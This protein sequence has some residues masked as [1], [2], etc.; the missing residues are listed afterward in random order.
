[1]HLADR[2]LCRGY[3][4]SVWDRNIPAN[5]IADDGSSMGAGSNLA[6]R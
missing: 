1:M 3:G 6:V 2:T 4:Y 5:R